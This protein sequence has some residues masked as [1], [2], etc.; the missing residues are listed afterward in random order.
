MGAASLASCIV[1]FAH[2]MPGVR[3]G[4]VGEIAHADRVNRINNNMSEV[5]DLASRGGDNFVAGVAAPVALPPASAALC[6]VMPCLRDSLL[7]SQEAYN[8]ESDT[9]KKQE[10]FMFPAWQD[11]TMQE[12]PQTGEARFQDVDLQE[13]ERLTAR[14]ELSHKEKKLLAIQQARPDLFRT[15]P[16]RRLNYA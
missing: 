7:A 14:E 1:F 6:R 13:W 10:K 12:I 8:T 3:G 4:I 11:A 5:Y 15:Q 2:I 16:R 9:I